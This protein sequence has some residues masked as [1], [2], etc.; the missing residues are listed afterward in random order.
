MEANQLIFC[1]EFKSILIYGAYVQDQLCGIGC[2][3]KFKEN[4]YNAENKRFALV[5]K[6][7]KTTNS[8]NT[9]QKTWCLRDIYKGMTLELFGSYEV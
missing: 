1:A 6:C 8:V 7:A 9:K 3:I 2:K 4:G 5:W